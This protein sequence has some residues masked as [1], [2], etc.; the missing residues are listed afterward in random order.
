ML[1]LIVELVKSKMEKSKKQD[2]DILKL[3]NEITKLS[4]SGDDRKTSSLLGAEEI[5]ENGKIPLLSEDEDI[6]TVVFAE[7]NITT[8]EVVIPEE[9]EEQE[10]L[11]P[12]EQEV[13]IPKEQEVPIPKEGEVL[14]PKDQELRSPF[15]NQEV[16]IPKET[17]K[18][19]IDLTYAYPRRSIRSLKQAKIDAR[20]KSIRSAEFIMDSGCN[21]HIVKNE[22][23]LFKVVY[24]NKDMGRIDG[25]VGPSSA[26]KCGTIKC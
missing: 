4:R 5:S 26:R 16:P 8:P 3:I 23:L 14:K 11:I 2:R 19:V 25:S 9:E 10:V 20:G 7:G 22:S 1:F 6:N 13:L 24:M 17:E 15:S 21:N 18:N 12:K